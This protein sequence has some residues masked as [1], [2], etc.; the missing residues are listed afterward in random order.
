MPPSRKRKFVTKDP[1]I[2]PSSSSRT[3]KRCKATTNHAV[4]ATPK[5]PSSLAPKCLTDLPDEL[6]LQ[7]LEFRGAQL[8]ER[9]YC[10]RNELFS[11]ICL[12]SR[13]LNRL[14]NDFLYRSFES[15]LEHKYTAKFVR[16]IIANP[17]LASRVKHIRWAFNTSACLYRPGLHTLTSRQE[18]C[19]PPDSKERR[20]LRQSLKSLEI[21]DRATWM[22][23]YAR[24]GPNMLKILLLHTPNIQKLY[25]VDYVTASPRW[26]PHQKSA[27]QLLLGAASGNPIGLAPAF[28]HLQTLN[29][30]M[31]S[32][33]LVQ[34]YPAFRLP[35][36]QVLQLVGGDR[37][38]LDATQSAAKESFPASSVTTLRIFKSH[39][40]SVALYE[41][42]RRC[43]P[44]RHFQFEY[45]H[46]G[47]VH[48]RLPEKMSYSD[49]AKAL[50]HHKQTIQ[51]VIL[52]DV[53]NRDYIELLAYNRETLGSFRSFNKLEILS[54]PMEAFDITEEAPEDTS[55]VDDEDDYL[56][57]SN[58]SAILPESLESLTLTIFEDEEHTDF[59]TE[60]LRILQQSY[61]N[62]VP[63]L[64]SITVNAHIGV[65]TR[66]ID[67]WSPKMRFRNSGVLFKIEQAGLDHTD[68]E[69]Y[70]PYDTYGYDSMVDMSDFDIFSDLD[71]DEDDMEDEE[72][73]GDGA[74]EDPDEDDLE[75]LVMSMVEEALVG[76]EHSVEAAMSGMI[77]YLQSMGYL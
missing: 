63:K 77:P 69:Y 1:T 43:G 24:G 19:P 28:S 65:D 3:A 76:T 62:T 39:M 46:N 27:A 12:V 73:S 21:P 17:A 68:R 70:D 9:D 42:V 20:L 18:D 60:S 32:M 6:L 56:P 22:D 47:T 10:G 54:A 49:V 36:L 72:G 14:G 25:V 40:S 48:G 35:S 44:L 74:E 38:T 16:T 4:A 41:L 29:L 33:S 67:F 23:E 57:H 15:R 37:T 11:N 66:C 50:Q 53:S 8:D 2:P 34:V 52:E 26:E 75:S 55:A 31:G 51:S 58:L 30:M 71:S 7:I 45:H 13:R 5:S 59:C 64:K 61:R